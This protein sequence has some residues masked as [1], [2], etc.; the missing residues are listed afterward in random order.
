[1]GNAVSSISYKGLKVS[2]FQPLLLPFGLYKSSKFVYLYI[3]DLLIKS[4][5]IKDVMVSELKELY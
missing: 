1:M 3:K 4:E 2:I 5:E